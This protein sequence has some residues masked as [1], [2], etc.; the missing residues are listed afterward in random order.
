VPEQ[1]EQLRAGRSW[2]ERTTAYWTLW[3]TL[4]ARDAWF[5]ASAPSVAL[6]LDTAAAA[7]DSLP[8]L[9]VLAADIIGGDQM[10]GWLSPPSAPLEP[11]EKAVHEAA[12]DRKKGL[13]VALGA[14]SAQTRGA[15]AMLL[16]MLPELAE[17]SV[18]RLIDLARTD[19]DDVAR[20]SA[21][22]A[23]GRL[24]AGDADTEGRILAWRDPVEPGF[25][26]GAA[27]VS[28]L[29]QSA[30]RRFGEASAELEEWLAFRAE[31]GDE[32]PWFK[33]LVWYRTLISPDALAWPLSALC[34]LRGAAGIEEL[35]D[36]AVSLGTRTKRGP[37][38]VQLAKILLDLGDFPDER[39]VYRPDELTPEQLAIAKRLAVTHLLAA[40]GPRLPA[41]GACRRRWIGMDPPSPLE[42]APPGAKLPRWRVYETKLISPNDFDSRLDYW[43]A[44]V[45]YSALSYPPIV[46]TLKPQELATQLAALPIGDELFALVP[47]L[48]DDLAERFEAAAR[49]GAPV[50]VNPAMSGMLLLPWVRAGKPLPRRWD[51]LIPLVPMGSEPEP[52]VREIFSAL[53]LD[54]REAILLERLAYNCPPHAAISV[55]DLAPTPRVGEAIARGIDKLAESPHTMVADQAKELRAELD[56][57]GT[58]YPSLRR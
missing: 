23:L 53:P 18:P 57:L 56:E 51:P 38:E 48:A 11:A 22:L 33:G 50:W 4:V 16:A 10:R 8:L 2:A 52:A 35:A 49:Q 54:R 14:E 46:R 6:L 3:E 12:T 47:Q 25:V 28:W 7:D 55:L 17:E 58:R 34:R 21:V 20:A 42:E 40:G 26:R 37:V 43:Q 31:S 39:G 15:A 9:L 41:S 13:F 1:V 30:D 5:E 29:R 27:A 24:G 32:L 45:E 36:F 19:Q 44:F